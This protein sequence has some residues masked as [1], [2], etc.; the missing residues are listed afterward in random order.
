MAYINQDKKKELTPTIKA[1][2][3]K[4]GIKATLSVRH[5]STLSINIKSGPIDFGGDCIQVNNYHYENMYSDRPEA[6]AFLREVIP[7]MNVGNFD[8]SDIMTDYFHVG[9][10]IDVN[11][12]RYDKPYQLTA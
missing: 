6:L 12:G 11:V 1:I 3:K 7:A 8:K 9:W 5:H 4:H 2:C 10:Y